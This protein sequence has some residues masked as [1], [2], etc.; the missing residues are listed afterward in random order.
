MAHQR[1][2]S[3]HSEPKEA[4]QEAEMHETEAVFYEYVFGRAKEDSALNTQECVTFEEAHQMQATTTSVIREAGSSPAAIVGRR[5]AELGEVL[6][7]IIIPQLVYTYSLYYSFTWVIT[8]LLI[9]NLRYHS[10]MP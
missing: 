3:I 5:L 1:V 4:E 9:L 10:V 8:L 6:F 2:V 7:T